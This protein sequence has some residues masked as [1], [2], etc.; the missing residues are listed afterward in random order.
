MGFAAVLRNTNHVSRV[1]K[2][3]RTQCMSA[4]FNNERFFVMLL[5]KTENHFSK[6]ALLAGEDSPI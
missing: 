3:V 4:E 1:P 2:D 6:F 5:L